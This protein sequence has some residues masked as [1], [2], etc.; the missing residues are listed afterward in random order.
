[1]NFFG[2]ALKDKNMSVAEVSKLTGVPQSTLFD[3]KAGRTTLRTEALAKVANCL[4]VTA[5]YLLDGSS[6][7]Y[8]ED[9]LTAELAEKLKDDRDLRLLFSA[10]KDAKPEALMAAYQ[11]LL[12]LK[13]MERGEDD[14]VV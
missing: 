5:E 8:Y 6:A 11:V 9:P 3:F 10:A 1:M 7:A 4:G 13:N 12:A 14:G 2:V